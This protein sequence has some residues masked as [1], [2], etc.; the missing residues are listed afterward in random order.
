MP[1]LSRSRTFA[2]AAGLCAAGMYFA[3]NNFTLPLYLS[4]FTSNNILIGWLSSTRSFEQWIIQPLVGARSDRTWTRFGRRAPFFLA[5]MP[6][7]AL[8]LI[9][10]GLIP[11]DPALLALVAV[12]IFAFSFLFNIGIDPYYALLADVT[13]S[14]QRGTVN[15][16]AQVFGFLGQAAI[17][18]G[19]FLLYGIHPAWVFGLVAVG[20]V[21]GF[22]IVGFGV[23]ESR[24][25]IRVETGRRPARRSLGEFNQYIL[26]LFREQ[27]EAMKLLVVRF[28]YQVGINAAV[29]FLT[30]FMAR[31]IGLTGWGDVLAI[32]PSDI[33]A[34][35]AK[36]D[37]GGLAQLM[38]AVLLL[39]TGIAAL[40]CGVLGDLFGKKR[41]FAAGLLVCGVTGLVAAFAT[42]VP[43]SL[44][45]MILLGIGNAALMV[46]FIPYLTDLI[47]AERVG[48]FVGLSAFAETGGILLSILL[49]GELINLNL[50]GLQYRLVFLVT[51]V[52]LLLA[53]AAVLFVKSSINIPSL[54]QIEG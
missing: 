16:I 20:L 35:L 38:A 47:P 26:A 25:R 19:A 44:F 27:P 34:S 15:G 4:I 31:E 28:L 50:F 53:F 1:P 30:L 6:L 39:S 10:N 51:S 17:L 5:A 41:V 29:P 45:Y 49:A 46:L 40:P 22:G 23:R 11:R 24:E 33:A 14:D 18:I 52:F 13:T 21:A 8:L 2:Y 42:D 3:F 37:P 7:V 32:L 36:I 54:S 9:F 43:Q 12:T 48:E